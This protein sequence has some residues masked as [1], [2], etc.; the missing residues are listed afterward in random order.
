[1]ARVVINN[2]DSGAT[3]RAAIN[4]M[5]AEIYSGQVFPSVANY[6]SLPAANTVS[7]QVYRVTTSTGVWLV[8]RQNK[9]LYASDG[10]NWNYIGDYPQTAADLANVPAGTI[11]S[12]NVQAAINELDTDVQ[13]K[14]NIDSPTFTG[15]VGGITKAM[16]G[17]G[18]VDNTS[19]VNKRVSTAQQTALNGKAATGAVGSTGITMTTA[20]LLGRSTA[21]TGAIEEITL[22]TNLSF[23]GT[24]LNASGGG[25]PGGSTT[26]VQ[27][28]SSG[29]FA[30]ATSALI[31]G[32][33]LR[34]PSI[35][36]PTTPAAS[37]AKLYGRSLGGRPTPTFSDPAGLS[38]FLQSHIG[39]NRVVLITA[40]PNTTTWSAVGSTAF[41]ATGTATA[42]AI[43]TTNLH[44][45]MGRM[46]TLVTVAAT[47]AVAGF[48]SATTQF[49]RGNAAGIGGFAINFI[50]GPATGPSTTS[51]TLRYFLGLGPNSSPT[52]VDPSSL[53]NIIGVG[54]DAADTQMQMMVN[55]NVVTAT[56]VPLGV[57]FPKPTADRTDVYDLQLFCAPNGTEI[58]YIVTKRNTGF[59]ASGSFTTDLPIST[60]NMT[61]YTYC[62]V[63][64]TSS[65]VGA[66]VMRFY[67]EVP[68]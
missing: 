17:L 56:K 9:G 18:N 12:T 30:G 58:F 45:S 13:L 37:G 39:Q 4:S 14:A 53:T 54:C 60:T 41:T 20:R 3:V 38:V 59:T 55:D 29:S 62:S 15:T 6:A 36:V 22:G 10:T 27:Y 67:A 47:T 11:V 46:D 21:A 61:P 7:G 16:V 50:G 31:E 49:L 25:S 66:A 64:G 24:T 65:V 2:G 33:E 32:N 48:R 40:V 34:L 51:G 1:M 42:A 5:T 57:N 26:Q 44:Q 28:N 35:S 43:G 68:N 52:D 63:G 19:D 8:N 23:T